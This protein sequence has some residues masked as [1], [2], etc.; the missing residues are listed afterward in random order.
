MGLAWLMSRRKSEW[1]P[2]VTNVLVM[3]GT[4]REMEVLDY[5]EMNV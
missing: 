4:L 2:V 5:K 3:C 1:E